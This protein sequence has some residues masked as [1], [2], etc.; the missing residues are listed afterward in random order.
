MSDGNN[1]KVGDLEVIVK[2]TIK[3]FLFLF[4]L[5]YAGCSS[6]CEPIKLSG[7]T[8]G[9]F[10][11]ITIIKSDGN[12]FDN[13]ILNI[14]SKIDSVLKEV[15]LQM[16]TYIPVSELS[17]FN[18][19][20]DTGW[21]SASAGLL[22]VIAEAKKISAESGNCFDITVGP[23]V[24]LWGFGPENRPEI[25]PSD[26]EIANRKNKIGDDKIEL[27]TKAKKIRKKIPGLYCDL[28]AIAKGYGVDAVGLFLE[29]NGI[30]NYLVEI[31]GEVRTRGKN[32]K[33]ED[34]KIGISS[35]NGG[36]GIQKIASISGNSIATSGDYRNYFEENGIR[37]S[38]TIDPRT[39]KPI[40]HKLVSVSVIS[41]DCMTADGYA[42]AIMVLGPE[43]GLAFAEK[44]NLPIF[45]IVK[46]KDG[47]K[48][49]MTESFK[50][51]LK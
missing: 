22:K 45:I 33:N 19:S 51:F 44:M 9:T 28:S 35:A 2:R 32:D 17:K 4:I 42:T 31:G 3:I 47:F 37:Y 26:G 27:D 30:E 39:G 23:L 34:W 36:N 15:N 8:M 10:Y 7:S 5:F 48:E 1:K 50:K 14:Q 6:K 11:N 20:T 49:K 25:I 13:L 21:I 29:K 12:E 40:N 18:S 16:S 43:E 46:E 24:N 41:K 38:H